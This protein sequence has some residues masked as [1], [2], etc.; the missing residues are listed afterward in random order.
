[1]VVIPSFLAAISSELSLASL[2]I[3]FLRAGVTLLT[4]NYQ[5]HFPNWRFKLSFQAALNPRRE[6]YHGGDFC[7][8]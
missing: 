5:V 1:M 8:L 7:M 3:N 2:E 6:F 4:A